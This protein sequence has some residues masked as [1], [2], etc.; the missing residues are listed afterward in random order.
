MAA[1][2]HKIS[3]WAGRK[4]TLSSEES[5]RQSVSSGKLRSS[6]PFPS[7]FPSLFPSPF[8][9]LFPS[10]SPSLRVPQA[11]KRYNANQAHYTLKCDLFLDRNHAYKIKYSECLALNDPHLQALFLGSSNKIRR[12]DYTCNMYTHIQN[13]F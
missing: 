9:F 2:I 10:L 11:N 3:V 13:Q 1:V 12:L 7:L 8:L 5:L 4:H 6:S